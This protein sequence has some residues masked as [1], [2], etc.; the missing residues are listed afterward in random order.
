MGL[1]G[2]LRFPL[3]EAIDRYWI[4]RASTQTSYGPKGLFVERT[5]Y[6]VRVTTV[7]EDSSAGLGL[8]ILFS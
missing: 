4:W 2:R 6:C 5:P 3:S 7:N 1:L 8:R